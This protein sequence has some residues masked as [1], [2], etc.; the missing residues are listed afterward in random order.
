M[1]REKKIEK[2]RDGVPIWDGD[3]TLFQE[4]EE[5]A[6][7]WE[8]GTAYH[9]RYLCAPRL[10]AELTGTARRHVMGK[11]AEW[12]S[13]NGGVQVL[14]THLRESL[15][16]PQ[17][18]ELTDYLLKYFKSGKRR[19]GEVMGHYITR[20]TETY[21]RTRQAL[22]R[23]LRQHGSDPMSWSRTSTRRED[24]WSRY[25]ST[26]PESSAGAE[27]EFHDV[28]EAAA[29]GTNQVDGDQDDDRHTQQGWDQWTYDD[30]W[31]RAQR[32]GWWQGWATSWHSES[33]WQ[34]P[35]TELLPDLVQGW[36]L[37]YDA[38]LDTGGRNMIIAATK[39]N[40]S[41]NR[42]AQELRVQWSDEDIKRHDQVSR[43]S[44]LWVGDD[45][46][47]DDGDDSRDQAFTLDHD[48]TE[49][50]WALLGEAQDEIDQAMV[51]VQQGKRTLREARE[52]QHQVKMSRKYFRTSYRGSSNYSKPDKAHTCLRCGNTGHRTANCPKSASTTASAS[53]TEEAAPFICYAED[54]DA[55]V[56]SQDPED[57]AE[58]FSIGGIT[59]MEA[60]QQGKAVIDGGATKTLASV[61]ALEK[62]MEINCAK[63][64]ASGIDHVN[65]DERPAFGF[66]NSSR[67]QCVST[68]SLA[69]N[70]DGRDGRL[71][72]HALNRG[73]GPLLFSVES[74][75]SLGAIVDYENDLIVFRKLNDQKV[76]PVERSCTGHQL[77]PMTDD[78]YA[79]AMP[80]QRPVPD[81][82]TFI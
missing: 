59:T 43:S 25:A 49:E 12:V 77:L 40:F 60:V 71:K 81:L 80:T 11:P 24:P 33:S 44:A 2:S 45:A 8:Q 68:A 52:K 13:F 79:K 69:I 46:S 37:L 22:A 75:R 51:M 65:L 82:R 21:A 62:I 10:M 14:M 3:A 28:S 63:K 23:V 7:L 34:S 66:G 16:L 4:Y 19:R 27:E 35:E 47:D 55:A 54:E 50:G 39:G 56:L 9:K 5:M 73:E 38:N 1:D 70:A 15:G 42:I 74:L 30:P 72:V 61:S 26:R 76:I 58:A 41:F 53:V 36:F 6:T 78:W 31:A 32:Q 20:K 29:S 18:P 67:D 17:L 64:G 48:L 57:Q